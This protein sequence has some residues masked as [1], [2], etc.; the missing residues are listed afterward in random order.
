MGPPAAFQAEDRGVRLSLPAPRMYPWCNGSIA[1]SKTVGRGSSPWGYAKKSPLLTAYIRLNCQQS[2]DP[3]RR[4]AC[5]R[6][7]P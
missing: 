7:Q 5:I 6:A 3:G 4:E 1:V 2:T